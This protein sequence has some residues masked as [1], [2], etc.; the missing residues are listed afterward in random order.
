MNSTRYWWGFFTF[1]LTLTLSV[2]C[3]DDEPAEGGNGLGNQPKVLLADMNQSTETT[4]KFS[5]ML[6]GAEKCY[7]FVQETAADNFPTTADEV[8]E[9]GTELKE[10]KS[11]NVEVSNLKPGVT[12]KVTAAATNGALKTMA[13]PIEMKTK[14]SDMN[15]KISDVVTTSNSITYVV[16]STNAGT[17]A[18]DYYEVTPAFEDNI[19]AYDILSKGHKIE[20]TTEPYKVL[21]EDLK[22]D[23]E[24]MIYAAVESPESN[25]RILTKERVRTAKLGAPEEMEEQL[26]TQGEV[27]VFRG[28]NFLVKTA[29]E[30]YELSLD[31]YS[32]DQFAYL[33]FIPEHEY[34]YNK[35]GY[36]NDWSVA[37]TTSITDK[38]S[39]EALDVVKGSL[40]VS[41]PSPSTYVIS[42]QFI[43]K[44]NKAFRFKYSDEVVYAMSTSSVLRKCEV[45]GSQQMV[46]DLEHTLL[47]IPL[48]A[49]FA[50]NQTY[51]ITQPVKMTVK[52]QKREYTLASARLA[53]ASDDNSIYNLTFT[54]TTQEGLKV[55]A[56]VEG[57]SVT[58]GGGEVPEEVDEEIVFES[59]SAT[60]LDSYWTTTY[61]LEMS[62]DE[63]EFVCQI[64]AD[65]NPGDVPVGKYIYSLLAAQGTPASGCLGENYLIVNRKDSTKTIN[66]LDNGEVVISKNND[67]SYSVAVNIKRSNGR[68]FKAQFKG[69]IECIYYGGGG[70]GGGWE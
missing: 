44:D 8:I 59:V 61:E 33:P 27:K 25:N 62:N 18:W 4:L 6:D 2:A 31:F 29:N 49:K 11:Q 22:D 58:V 42:G 47:E 66:D 69:D 54:G 64:G 51:T 23:T 32:A 65:C 17:A 19:E 37:Q 45:K 24:Y 43:T 28:K 13:Q 30:K 16:N 36:T 1:I 35:G 50:A 26:F 38:V 40:T 5:V 70:E 7:Y 52:S 46:L 68:T 9:R 10:A 15:V 55:S 57:I 67:G 63:W 21:V 3:G 48:P 20:N 12:Y 39:G 34:T 53:V 14:A 41:M 56:L 60:V